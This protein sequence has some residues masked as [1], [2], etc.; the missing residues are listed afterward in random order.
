MRLADSY[1]VPRADFI[2]EYYG[3]ELDQ[4]WLDRMGKCGTASGSA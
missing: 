3:N 2:Y 1:G 4:T